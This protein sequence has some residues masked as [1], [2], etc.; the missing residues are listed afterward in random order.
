M[1]KA[2]NFLAGLVAGAVVGAAVAVLLAPYSGPELQE[3]MRT[4]VQNL[5]E[6][7]R[8]AATVR[9]D[10][11]KAQLDTFKRGTPAQVEPE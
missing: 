11:L 10:E 1:R 6:E 3:R 9:R 5:I 7:G 2:F 8:R 4:R